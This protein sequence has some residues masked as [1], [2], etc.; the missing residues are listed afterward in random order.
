MKALCIAVATALMFTAAAPSVA[1]PCKDAKGKFVK[2]PEKKAQPTR[3]KDSRGKFVKCG[4]PG[5]KP[6]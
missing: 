1:A 5:A 6:V 4:T 3:C 2:C